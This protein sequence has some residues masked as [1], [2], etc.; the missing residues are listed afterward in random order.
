MDIVGT[1][2]YAFNVAVATLVDYLNFNRTVALIIS[3]FIAGGISSMINKNF[4]IKYFGSET[5]KHISYL[6][7]SVSGCL[8]A[9]CSCTI[10]PLFAGIYRRGAGIGP[11]TTFL[12][13][14][15]AI[16]VL[17]LFYSAAL[18][19]WGIGAIR[20]TF[21]IILSIILGLTMALL[22]SSED[23]KRK[24]KIS[25]EEISIRPAYQTII[26][27]GIQILMLLA[28]T[29]SH[30]L[31]P[32]LSVALFNIP[33]FGA[34]LVK[35]IITGGLLIL[36]IGIVK[37]WFNKEE[38]NSWLRETVILGKLVIPLLLFGVALA[39]VLSAFLP[40]ELVSRFV[41]GNSLSANFIASFI[42]APMYFATLTEVPIVK[43]L[44]SLGMGAG[45]AMALL[46]A[47][48]SLSIPTILTI[49]RV[50]GTKKALIYLG[51][52]IV[53]STIAGLITG[54]ILG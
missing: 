6:V 26:F 52:V 4:I 42:G 13:S 21:A 7:A 40:S 27:F 20:G 37:S 39:G 18:L 50:I 29:A 35:H 49:S 15:P 16:N 14:G 10:L 22:F 12:F 5:P 28:I 3:F 43:S 44:M 17:A 46:L 23:K 2:I 48:P 24:F 41:G 25:A 32:S 31:I 34:V 19:G 38:I 33:I 54:M 53:L 30:T 47:G 36:L 1:L 9:V 8:L 51:N 11:A 45:P